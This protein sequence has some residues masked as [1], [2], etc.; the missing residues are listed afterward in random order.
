[1]KRIVPGRSTLED[2][3]AHAMSHLLVAGNFH[4][5]GKSQAAKL[6][7]ALMDDCLKRVREIISTP[8]GEPVK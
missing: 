2:A 7:L 6:E 5:H 3:I 4:L 8:V 1:M